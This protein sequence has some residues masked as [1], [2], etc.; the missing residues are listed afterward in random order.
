MVSDDK[1]PPRS[2]NP[3][4]QQAKWG[5]EKLLMEAP[6]G[7]SKRIKVLNPA[8]PQNDLRWPM[9]FLY[10]RR[11]VL[12]EDISSIWL[13]TLTNPTQIS[14]HGDIIISPSEDYDSKGCEDPRVTRIDGNYV[15]TYVGFDG[16]N[17]R[18]V[19][20][21]TE[22][23]EVIRK[24]G[25]IGPNLALEEVLSII[26][27]KDYGQRAERRLRT[28]RD[29]GFK[30]FIAP[31]NK[32]AAEQYFPRIKKFGLWMRLEPHIQLFL[33]DKPE[34]FADLDYWRQELS[35][36]RSVNTFLFAEG[37]WTSEKIGNGPHP[38]EIPEE[39]RVGLPF[40]YLG[41]FHGVSKVDIKYTYSGGVYGAVENVKTGRVEAVC[42]SKEPLFV[43][44]EDY[45]VLREYDQ[46][47]T[48]VGEKHVQFPSAICIDP[49]DSGVWHIYS[50]NGDDRIGHREV[51][52][53]DLVRELS[54]ERSRIAA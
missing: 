30:G 12:N 45:P 41:V 40:E 34:D 6:N 13:T 38:V 9:R 39:L 16:V 28:L 3:L 20:A 17:A 37:G 26:D 25:V 23:F 48:L 29:R 14:G 32:D 11:D 2:P 21:V 7:D 33:A 27:D 42:R 1:G 51:S 31:Y 10:R 8:V 15:I 18:P 49:K 46:H 4:S 5:V 44:G 35:R 52:F 24:E 36:M 19:R 50:G 22:D 43:P 53:Y 54:E 47:G